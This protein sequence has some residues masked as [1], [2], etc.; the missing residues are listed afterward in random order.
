M[1]FSSFFGML[2][3]LTL[4][5]LGDRY[6]MHRRIYL[7][8][9]LLNY[10]SYFVLLVPILA[11]VTSDKD[12]DPIWY[13][14]IACCLALGSMTTTVNMNLSDSFSTNVARHCNTSYGSIKLWSTTGWISSSVALVFVNK[15]KAPYLA[16]MFCL[17]SLLASINILLVAWW[18][19]GR[20]FD[21][22]EQII[23][24]TSPLV[25]NDT[26]T[27]F[28]FFRRLRPSISTLKNCTVDLAL[29]QAGSASL[30]TNHKLVTLKGVIQNFAFDAG[31]E[32]AHKNIRRCSL[33][34]LGDSHIVKQFELDMIRSG[35]DSQTQNNNKEGKH[36]NFVTVVE[37]VNGG[38]V[39]LVE[40]SAFDT[41]YSSHH[42]QH[43]NRHQVS[44]GQAMSFRLHVKIIELIA[45]K[46]NNV[47][48]FMFLYVL[49][50]FT[51]AMNWVYLMPY[52]D[53]IDSPKF[54]SLSSYVLISGYLGETLFYLVAP[55]LT[56]LLTH[57]AGMS[58]VMLVFA[59]RY[60]LYL[61]FV[62]WPLT[63]PMEMV[64]GI[65]LLQSLS[66][67]WFNCTFNAVALEFALEARGC[68]PRLVELGLIDE[69]KESVELVS[70]S[71]NST[72]LSLSSCC[73]DGIGV[74][75]GSLAGGWIIN[76]FGFATLWFTTVT[77]ALLVACLNTALDLS[78]LVSPSVTSESAGTNK[79]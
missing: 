62:F 16:P 41:T 3:S 59:L 46:N 73:F 30:S 9:L 54:R 61:V 53:S 22:A 40:F 32:S 7:V 21:L 44:S 63:L 13:Y 20:P 1:L 4:C 79:T 78:G 68:V 39:K 6:R 27:K 75:F 43:P 37:P 47:L 42:D 10:V 60:S 67:G 24:T 28:K 31:D 71:V 17:F 15:F 56:K 23:T 64:I 38:P 76:Q 70:N 77:I 34:P 33:A 25:G 51:A 65:E 5:S 58:F 45:R 52:L 11:D 69:T 74:A 18:P 55:R 19:D 57:S 48:R 12:Y 49:T 35:K 8:S 14:L 2:L 29:Q 36:F 66:M 72:F 26:G 50:G